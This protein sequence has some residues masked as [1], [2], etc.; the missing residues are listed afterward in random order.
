MIS[1]P[2][3][4]GPGAGGVTLRRQRALGRIRQIT[5]R[6]ELSSIFVHAI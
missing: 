4:C 5:L 2:L 1:T 6:L 3:L